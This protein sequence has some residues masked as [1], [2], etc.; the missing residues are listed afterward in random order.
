MTDF[1][2]GGRAPTVTIVEP[3]ANGLVVRPDYRRWPGSG[4]PDGNIV[5]QVWN[6]HGPGITQP[7]SSGN[8]LY[9]NLGGAAPATSLGADG[10]YVEDASTGAVWGPKSNGAWPAFA[11]YIPITGSEVNLTDAQATS[12]TDTTQGDVSGAQIAK[13]IAAEVGAAP[14]VPVVTDGQTSFTLPSVPLNAAS[15]R[16]TVNGMSYRAP[17][18]SVTGATVVWQG[19]FALASSDSV[20]IEYQ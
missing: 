2:P 6:G 14:Y 7:Q 1:L 5:G 15:V 20:L 19:G 18:I 4:Y 12:S 17:D 11:V 13:A 8:A 9:M 3:D 10:S 16:V